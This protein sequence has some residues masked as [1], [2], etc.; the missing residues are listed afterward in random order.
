MIQKTTIQVDSTTLE[1]IKRHKITKRDSYDEIINRL[2]EQ[3][4]KNN[5]M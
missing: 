3:K 4:E 2:L 5:E 1:S